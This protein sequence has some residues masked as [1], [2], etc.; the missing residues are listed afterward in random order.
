MSIYFNSLIT[1]E[2]ETSVCDFVRKNPGT[3]IIK[4]R[5]KLNKENN[6]SLKTNDVK[7]ILKHN[8]FNYNIIKKMYVQLY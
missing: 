6:T 3:N 7:F 8:D 5:N 1:S 2:I 4:L